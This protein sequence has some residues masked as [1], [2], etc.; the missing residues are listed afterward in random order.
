MGVAHRTRLVR[1]GRRHRGR[2][3]LPEPTGRGPRGPE[4]RDRRHRRQGERPGAV[5]AVGPYVPRGA[6]GVRLQVPRPVGG[7][8]H[9][10]HRRAGRQ[11]RTTDAGGPAGTGRRRRCDRLASHLTQSRGDSRAGRE[12]RRRGARPACRRRDSVRRGGR[13]E[14]RRRD[15]RLPRHLS[16]L[17]GR[18]RTRRTARL[19]S[20]R[21]RLSRA[22]EGCNRALRRAVGTGHRR[23][24]R[25][26]RRTARGVGAGRATP[27]PVRPDRRGP[28]RTG[29]VGPAVGGEPA[30][31]TG[32][33]EVARAR[34]LPLG[35]GHP[36]GRRGDGPEPRAGV[37]LTR[38]S[39]RRDSGGTGG[40]RRRGRESRG[41][42][43]RLPD[44][45]GE[46]RGRRRP[47]RPRRRPRSRSRD[48]RRRAGRP[49]VRLHRVAVGDAQ[50]GAGT[51]RGPRRER[52][53]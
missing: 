26:A 19:L 42:D 16:G 48:R 1:G 46:P 51:R 49:D 36:R 15:L 27:G 29:G 47:A 5:R 31:G 37:R 17:R 45:A 8:P 35:A 7:D 33:V 34:R 4:L 9:R 22:G 39:A 20:G 12:R 21:T 52:D 10:R 50:R 2:H 13:G 24:R 11:N 14:A 23:A 44:D 40:G 18:H 41:V 30:G 28:R 32:G 38:R 6:V 3:R 43:S 25:G 53:Q